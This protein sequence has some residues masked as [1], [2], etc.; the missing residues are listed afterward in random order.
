MAA[1]TITE[2]LDAIEGIIKTF[3]NKARVYKSHILGVEEGGSADAFRSDLDNR[4]IRAYVIYLNRNVPR[5]PG[6]ERTSYTLAHA[7]KAYR[8]DCNFSFVIKRYLGYATG[9]ND[10]NSSIEAAQAYMDLMVA[11][12]KKPKLGLDQTAIDSH[13]NLQ[14]IQ[15]RG[16]IGA[17]DDGAHLLYMQ[18]DVLVYNTIQ[19]A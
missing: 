15:D 19:P 9:T 7:M 3:D 16:V 10:V 1:A 2:L 6:G 5:L 8:L 4:R 12:A 13:T 14:L 11:I 17:N 18:L